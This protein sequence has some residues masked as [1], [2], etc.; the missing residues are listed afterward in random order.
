MRR[1]RKSFKRPLRPW[2]AARIAEQKIVMNQ[3]GLRRNNEL[4]KSIAILRDY[5]QR[6]RKLIGTRHDVEIKTLTS[7]LVKVGLIKHG[8]G[9]DDVLALEIKNVLERRLQTI[10]FRKGLAK[11]A[12]DARQ[13][14]VH[15][16]V[17]VAGRKTNIPSYMVTADDEDKI[18]L[19][20]VEAPKHVAK[21]AKADEPGAQAE[22]V[23]E[24]VK[25]TEEKT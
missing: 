7:K 25:E 15:G 22:T 8:Q 14:I 3:Y 1:I 16:H 13:K 6:A 9:I 17:T 19:S 24:A 23:P 10:V 11:T 12:F 21:H 4:L 20:G 5:R 2:D 18:S